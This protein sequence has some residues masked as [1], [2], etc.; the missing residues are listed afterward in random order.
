MVADTCFGRHQKSSS[1]VSDEGTFIQLLKELY[2]VLPIR[3]IYNFRRSLHGMRDKLG[4]A[5]AGCTT[6]CRFLHYPDLSSCRGDILYGNSVLKFLGR[7][8]TV[9]SR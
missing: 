2:T 9:V 5:E 7:N 3:K 8:M 4:M 1:M 6:V